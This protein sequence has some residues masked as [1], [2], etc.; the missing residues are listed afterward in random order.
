M[1]APL[2]L[3]AL[4]AVLGGPGASLLARARWT[5]RAP[6]L[7][8]LAW[9]ALTLST[10]VSLTLAGFSLAVPELPDTDDVASFI[11][12]CSEALRD[13]Y[14]TPGGIAVS[15]LGG[16]LATGLVARLG[17][18]LVRGGLRT[19]RRRTHQRELLAVVC[20][21][22]DQLD[23]VVIDH[24]TPVVYCLPGRPRQI[25]VSEGA[26]TT[27]SPDQLEQ[28]LVHERAHIHA[29]HHWAVMFAE[30]LAVTLSNRLGTR[31]ARE[32]I[33]DLAEMHAD[34]A[35]H[36]SHRRDL[37]TAVFLLAGGSRPLGAL[38]AAG[39]V[40]STRVRRLMLPAAPVSWCERTVLLTMVAITALLPVAITAAPAAT[41]ALVD[42]CPVLG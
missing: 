37:A 5:L 21:P 29:R 13:H 6:A 10:F 22:H 31:A 32:H 4:V 9:Q 24:A 26:L 28:V 15:I 27:L 42:Y 19:Y 33:A 12:A 11:H 20:R 14:S 18:A 23:V 3:L 39:G 30:A 8:I 25:V 41:A 35:V 2:A 38:G 1:S 40:V 17:F 36:S 34:D 7:G 16:M